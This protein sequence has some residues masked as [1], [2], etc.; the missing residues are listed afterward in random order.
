MATEYQLSV[1]PVKVT[2]SCLWSSLAYAVLACLIQCTELPPEDKLIAQGHAILETTEKWK[3]G[4]TYYKSVA[5]YSREKFKGES[6]NWHCRVSEHGPEDATFDE[7]W[8]RLAVN[9]G[10]NEVK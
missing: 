8:S 1:T 10:E 6:A 7:F 3:Q 4:K 9:K 2:G 5:T